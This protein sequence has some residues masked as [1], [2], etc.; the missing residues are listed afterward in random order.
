MRRLAASVGAV[1]L[2]GACTGGDDPRPAA[3]A[4][5]TAPV[6]AT[7]PP[8]LATAPPKVTVPSG[9]RPTELVVNDITKGTGPF[10]LPGD[11]IAVH[12]VGV[13][14]DGGQQF[15]SSWELGAPFRF[16]VGNEEVAP[17]LD[18][19]VLGMRVGGRRRLVIPPDLLDPAL[20]P[21]APEDAVV[22]VVDVMGVDKGGPAQ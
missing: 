11:M 13:T 10:V 6:A 19:G 1:L 21:S 18:R 12:Y 5:A 16:R 9:P 17:G 22:L 2:L 15:T 14:F 20:P 8:V 3:S 4:T 7:T